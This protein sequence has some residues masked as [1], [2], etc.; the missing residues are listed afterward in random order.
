MDIKSMF[1][2]SSG[3]ISRRT[4]WFGTLMLIAASLVI[5]LVLALVGLGVSS[6]MPLIVY[7][8]MIYP[9]YNLGLKRRH[10]RDNPGQD[11]LILL[12]GSAVFTILQSLGI[13]YSPVD[14]GN[15]FV[16]M[17]P[18]LWMSLL[19]LAFAIF[20]IYMLVQLGF[21]KGTTGDNSYGPDPL[22]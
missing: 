3:R 5:N 6:W 21:L 16:G 9:A 18:D 19:Q 22:A 7:L 17:M 1:L 10:D 11:Y 4:W 8:L 15:G 14:L 12:A 13:G 2:A 20:G